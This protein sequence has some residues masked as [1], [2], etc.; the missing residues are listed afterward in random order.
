RI[1]TGRSAGSGSVSQCFW[2]IVIARRGKLNRGWA[3]KSRTSIDKQSVRLNSEGAN[4]YHM[5]IA[6]VFGTVGQSFTDRVGL[7]GGHESQPRTPRGADCDHI[8]SG[9]HLCKFV[10]HVIPRILAI[11]ELMAASK[12]P[13]ALDVVGTGTT[14]TSSRATIMQATPA[15]APQ[16]SRL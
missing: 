15:K 13:V 4:R 3:S 11:E 16:D 14:K 12:T 2:G 7:I 5:A 6:V 10:R 8:P 9:W 1:C